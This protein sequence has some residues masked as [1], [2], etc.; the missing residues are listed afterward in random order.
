MNL[1]TRKDK[2]YFLKEC[3]LLWGNR[4]QSS[5]GLVVRGS[6]QEVLQR[7]SFRKKKKKS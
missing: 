3:H 2:A 4:K 7:E 6:I 1:A 5:R